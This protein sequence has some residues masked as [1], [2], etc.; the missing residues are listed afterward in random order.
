VPEC[1]LLEEFKNLKR[2]M[3]SQ[4]GIVSPNRFVHHVQQVAQKTGRELFTGWAQNDLPEFLLFIVD[5][6]H[7][8][9]S[10]QVTMRICGHVVNPI[11]QLAMECYGMLRSTYHNE[12]S[13]ILK[14]HARSTMA[15]PI[16]LDERTFSPTFLS[17][18]LIYISLDTV[19]M[20]FVGVNITFISILPYHF[21]I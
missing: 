2:V 21:I 16:S 14:F 17:E 19:D 12:Y 3:W 11:D 5:A 10:R 4:N 9:I 13:E 8:S 20:L 1:V 18:H 15:G 7:K 6:I